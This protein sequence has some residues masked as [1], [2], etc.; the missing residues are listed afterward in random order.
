MVY[1]DSYHAHNQVMGRS[2][3][4]VMSFVVSTPISRSSHRQGSIKTSSYSTDFCVRYVS[5]EEATVM[6]CIFRSNIFT[7]STL[8]GKLGSLFDA[9]YG[10]FQEDLYTTLT[11]MA[12][13]S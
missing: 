8:V 2:I 5:T 12:T 11:W 10:V 3:S 1:F 7:K 9:S 13:T 4:S 6:H